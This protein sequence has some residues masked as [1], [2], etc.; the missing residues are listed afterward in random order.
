MSDLFNLILVAIPIALAAVVGRLT[1][2]HAFL[3]MGLMLLVV[4][5]L[6]PLAHWYLLYYCLGIGNDPNDKDD[7]V[8]AGLIWLL[9]LAEVP[10][11]FVASLVGRT[12]GRLADKSYGDF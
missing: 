5:S 3:P 7:V 11:C 6:Y 8:G 2:N 1:A 4:A 10:L 12:V 9:M